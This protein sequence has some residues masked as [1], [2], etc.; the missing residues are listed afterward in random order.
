MVRISQSRFEMGSTAKEV[1]DAF[2]QCGREPHGRRCRLEEFS[3]ERPVRRVT[4]ATFRIDRFE[5]SVRDYRNCV[6]VGRCQPVPRRGRARRFE[7]AELPMTL[8]RWQ[9]A[10]DYCSFRGARLPTEAEFER[11][12]AGPHRRKYPWG[13]LYDSRLGNHGRLATDRTDSADG[14]RELAPVDSFREGSTPNGITN[15][16]GNA[17]E[18]V[19]DR[20]AVEYDRQDVINP[21]GPISSAASAFR[22]VRG[23]S[24]T[25]AR[26]SLRSTARDYAAPT[27]RALDRGF[28]CAE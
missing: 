22:V 10:N 14:Y 23:G 7:R 6:R 1:V 18:W 17:S 26:T 15:L 12:S 20:Y 2:G 11:A 19:W 24:Y 16:S 4:L 27:D 3:H 28:R 9:D 25:S 5:V 13:A 21:K 8:V